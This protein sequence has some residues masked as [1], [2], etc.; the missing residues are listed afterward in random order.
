MDNSISKCDNDRILW[1]GRD[2][3]IGAEL[4]FNGMTV[5]LNSMVSTLINWFLFSLGLWMIGRKMG[6]KRPLLAWIPGI[7]YI[8]LGNN[9]NMAR[10]GIFIAI[11]EAVLYAA[12]PL[13]QRLSNDRA[14]VAISLLILILIVF[15]LVYR[16]RLLIRLIQAFGRKK[17]WILLW[18]FAADLSALI[19]GFSKKFQPVSTSFDED[20]DERA[21]TAPAEIAG[22]SAL[23]RRRHSDTG[24]SV[25]LKER[26]A[27]DFGKKRYL[28]KD[29]SL[30]IPN[31]S[32]VL[33]LGGSGSG[34]TT[35]VNAIIGYEKA[36][37]EV[38][39]NGGDIYRNYSRMKYK[40]GF[41]PQKNLIR[42][43]DSVIQTVDDAAELRLPVKE[44]GRKRKN[45]V[46]EV[47]DLLGLSAG[48]SGLVSKKSGGQLR[49]ICIAM[50]LVSNPDLLILDEPDSGL[51]GVIAR[52]I[53]SKLRA[54]ADEGKIV[55]VITH[56]P[57][58]VIDLFDKV[59]VLGRDSGRCGRLA[60]YGSPQEAR[61]F[62]G[63]DTMEGIVM[64]VNRKEEGGDG[65]ADH[66]I[67]R[68]AQL[69]AAAEGGV[70]A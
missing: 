25:D 20:D 42:G 60:F 54:I 43:N 58:R 57:D 47:M 2:A 12:S 63:K 17:S 5:S 7:R 24:L 29:I 48:A 49:R 56:T 33:L 16:I 15:M 21:G 52:E 18:I 69:A 28:L 3:V 4:T 14:S 37:A 41:V 66:F 40:I 13:V 39:L 50:E 31:G 45:R 9:L 51:D 30:D 62:F 44:A 70:Q 61:E 19:F 32:L 6:W 46:K 27:R 59:I 34:K 22:A 65:L 38:T 67:E 1:L 36:D 11:A 53:F 26:T 64:S 55:I 23:H 35:L 8:A 10:E 68:Y